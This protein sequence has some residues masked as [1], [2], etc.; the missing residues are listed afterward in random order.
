MPL[1]LPLGSSKHE[2]KKSQSSKIVTSDHD[3]S[4]KREENYQAMTSPSSPQGPLKKRSALDDLTNREENYQA[5][6]SPSSPQG[7]LKKRSALDVLTN[8][9]QSQPIQSKKEANKECV[10]DVSKKI[11]RNPLGL[12]ESNE[13]NIKKYEL[14][15]SS[16]AVSP[17]V[18]THIMKKPI[19]LK[20]SI[21]SKIPTTEEA[22]LFKKPSV[23]KVKPTTG[24]T[25]PIKRPLSFKKCRNEYKVAIVEKPL[26]L[27]EETNFD[28]Y[29]EP[30]T[31]RP[32]HKTE[33]TA[34][35]KRKLFF[36]RMCTCQ[37][38]HSNCREELTLLDINVENDSFFMEPVN[39]RRKPNTEAKKK[40]LICQK[41][42]S[43]EKSLTKEPLFNEALHLKLFSLNEKPTTEKELSFEEPLALQDN[44]TNDEDTFL[45]DDSILQVET[46][47]YVVSTALESGIGMSSSGTMS[48]VNKFN[49]T[50]KSS[51]CESS[52]N[53][54]FSP[55]S[56]RL[57]KEQTIPLKDIDTNHNDILCN[58]IYV[59][60]IFRYMKEREEKFILK[61]YID[62][63]TDISSNMRAILV[64]WLVD[65]QIT[66]QMNHETLYLAMKLVDHYL[67]KVICKKDKLQLLG[68]SAFLI[69]AK[70]QESC[71]PSV[72]D[73]LYICNDA[74][75]QDEILTMEIHILQTLEY[76]INIPI[77]YH[78][79]RK[80]SWF[81]PVNT[82]T[83]ILS[84][85]ICEMTLQEYDFIQE[86]AS[87]LAAASFLLALYMKKLKHLAPTL[88][89]YSG[90]KT[91]DLHP[92]V[93]K[94][95]ILLTLRSCDDKLKAVRSK[96]SHL[97]FS[98]VSKIPPL[99][100]LKLEDIFNSC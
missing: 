47:P 38:K 70:F 18:V 64:N 69:A 96:Y 27:L 11:N 74:Y 77:A 86:R 83:A 32:K 51:A 48:N 76:D 30:V 88:E 41:V 4:E 36:Q 59:K 72:N 60:D 39:F 97:L 37:G 10:K 66:F 12:A 84:R 28:I 63:Q 99:D 1:P 26:T 92:L 6:T 2:T 71:S 25:L 44:P 9:S 98:E 8:A 5:M 62:R 14:E 20:R 67:M 29:L 95:N 93:K 22:S 73:L 54:P 53:K 65:V 34:I 52:S 3:N 46:S 19:I 91:S 94:L 58:S 13:M 42:T 68:S 90:Y 55:W 7:P 24:N 40:P 35:T 17:T 23:L 43:K 89:Y 56:K 21:I 31:H 100:L 78:F 61:K 79:L 45:K 49:T 85:F 81:V 80:Y 50:K 75:Q 87:M 82:N 33:E 57:R 15:P 16:A